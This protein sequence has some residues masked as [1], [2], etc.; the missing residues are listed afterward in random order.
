M[1]RHCSPLKLV[2]LS[3]SAALLLLSV[4]CGTAAQDPDASAAQAVVLE[5][6]TGGFSLQY[7]ANFVKVEPDVS[8]QSGLIYQVFLADPTGAKSGGS[9]LDVLGITV[10]EISRSAKPGDL[11]KHRDEFE[12]MAGQLVGTPSGLQLSGPFE[13]S[14][15]GGRPALKAEY[16]YKAGDADV[17]TV[18]YLVPLGRRVYWITGQASRETWDTTG[19]AIGAAMSTI[20]FAPEGDGA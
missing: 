9:S 1:F 15:L 3:V 13:L 19:K 17:A 11:K 10:R 20:E 14:E 12:A 2:V 16:V 7:P 6:K 5:S 8:S 18:A 4:G